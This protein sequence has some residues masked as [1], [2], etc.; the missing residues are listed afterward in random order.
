MAVIACVRAAIPG[1][2]WGVEA[3]PGRSGLWAFS[4]ESRDSDADARAKAKS[5]FERMR[6]CSTGLGAECSDR[7]RSPRTIYSESGRVH[8]ERGTT[9]SYVFSISPAMSL[10][11]R[12]KLLIPLG[13]YVNQQALEAK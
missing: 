8:C 3:E 10:K 7:R 5:I 1:R 2:A 12:C 4:G 13:A 11:K 9:I 6:C